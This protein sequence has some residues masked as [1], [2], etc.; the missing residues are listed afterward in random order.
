MAEDPWRVVFELEV[1]L[2]GGGKLV[3]GSGRMLVWAW[4]GDTG[5]PDELKLNSSRCT[6]L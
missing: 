6:M 5:L 1:V 4:T 2:G 3:T